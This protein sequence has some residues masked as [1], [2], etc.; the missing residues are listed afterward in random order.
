MFNL[1]TVLISTSPIFSQLP[2]DVDLI[3]AFIH[4]L[5]QLNFVANIVK[6]ERILLQILLAMQDRSRF[7][8]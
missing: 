6:E 8:L 3:S 1:M 7:L 5:H 2:L 4:K